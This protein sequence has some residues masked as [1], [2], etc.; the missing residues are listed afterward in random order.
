MYFSCK[1]YSVWPQKRNLFICT[2]PL[3]RGGR[4]RCCCCRI[5]L[6]MHSFRK[7][8]G[9][10]IKLVQRMKKRRSNGD[11]DREAKPQISS[12]WMYTYFICVCICMCIP[13]YKHTHSNFFVAMSLLHSAWTWTAPWKMTHAQSDKSHEILFVPEIYC[14]GRSTSI[15]AALESDIGCAVNAPGPKKKIKCMTLIFTMMSLRQFALPLNLNASIVLKINCLF[16][17][18]WRCCIQVID[19]YRFTLKYRGKYSRVMPMIP[20]SRENETFVDWSP[21]THKSGYTW[22]TDKHTPN[23]EYRTIEYTIYICR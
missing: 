21:R 7:P 13:C 1:P 5:W 10:K 6:Q 17:M 3:V 20:I 2:N 8:A 23:T 14:N 9:A 15:F 19:D 12:G 4:R 18:T 11:G 16:I 22:Y